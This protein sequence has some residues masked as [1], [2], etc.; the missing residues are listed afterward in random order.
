MKRRQSLT[1]FLIRIVFT[2]LLITGLICFLLFLTIDHFSSHTLKGAGPLIV[3]TSSLISCIVLGTFL[4]LPVG[5]HLLKPMRE[6]IAATKEVA[7]GNFNVR[8]KT[9]E[10]HINELTE[11]LNSFNKMTE[12]LSGIEM[13][14]NDFINNFSHEFK[15]PIVSILGFTKLLKHGNLPQQQM[16]T[17][18]D[19]IEEE[20]ERLAAMATNVLNMAKIENQS[21]LTDVTAFNLS[22]QLRNCILLLEKKWTA[23]S[24]EMIVTFN[25]HMIL[26]NEELLKQVWI[27][28]LDNAVKF[29]PAGGEIEVTIHEGENVVTV[30]ITNT[31]S[32]IQNNDQKRIFQ[33]FYQ[34]DTSHASEGTGIG[35]AVVKKIVELHKGEVFAQ[36]DNNQTTFTVQLPRNL[37]E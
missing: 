10:K 11:L 7:N 3:I 12:E 14:R 27:N 29:T 24:L 2:I 5:R 23:K 13:F 21:I 16:D 28:L 18:L 26:A 33:K 36:S 6:L 32:T 19:V 20:S 31:G 17:Y 37:G 4:S 25:E 30:Q 35:L 34:A 1:F 15:T 22:E 8:V 9:E